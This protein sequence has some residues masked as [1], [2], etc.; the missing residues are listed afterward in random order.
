MPCLKHVYSGNAGMAPLQRYVDELPDYVE[1]E[2]AGRA[3][4][5]KQDEAERLR[6]AKFRRRLFV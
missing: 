2:L 5:M 3:P 1:P 4:A 6:C